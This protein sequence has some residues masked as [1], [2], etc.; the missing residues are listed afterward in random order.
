MYGVT[1]STG[2]PVAPPLEEQVYAESAADVCA[3]LRQLNRSLLQSFLELTKL[4]ASS[5]SQCC[6]KGARP[7]KSSGHHCCAS[8][9]THT[10]AT[11]TTRTTR[12]TRATRAT[13]VT[14]ITR[15]TP[16]PPAPH[17]HHPCHTRATHTTRTTHTTR[18]TRATRAVADLRTLFLNFQHLLNTYRPHEARE[19]LIAIVRQQAAAKRQLSDELEAA[20]AEAARSVSEELREPAEADADALALAPPHH[21][22]A[23]AAS[24]GAAAA[25]PAAAAGVSAE[26]A[27]D[28]PRGRIRALERLL[29][30]LEAVP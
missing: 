24:A 26:E 17:P 15:T 3:E 25:Q 4:M 19:A 21:A 5:P 1:R 16:A 2:P 9:A 8:R 27:Q 7:A 29:T 18:A 14:R 6:D 22:P 10:R 28:G 23:G 30:T 12:A 13:C 11:R 20:C